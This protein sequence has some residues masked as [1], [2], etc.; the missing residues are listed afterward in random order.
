[1][2]VTTKTKQN[3]DASYLPNL[4]YDEQFWS[5]YDKPKIQTTLNGQFVI[6]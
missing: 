2:K 6:Y 5:N 4:V 1:M 3:S